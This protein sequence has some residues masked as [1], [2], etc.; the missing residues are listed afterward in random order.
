M[1][2]LSSPGVHR[3]STSSQRQGRRRSE[4]AAA[5]AHSVLSRPSRRASR[6]GAP[7]SA[8]VSGTQWH[9]RNRHVSWKMGPRAARFPAPYACQQGQGL[10]L[11]AGIR[12]LNI[13][14][15]IAQWS[16]AMQSTDDIGV[17]QCRFEKSHA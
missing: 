1:A 12:I 13:S 2:P 11:P 16:A 6:R 10:G 5:M 14:S 9:A 8:A 17:S 4:Y 3:L 15:H 7:S